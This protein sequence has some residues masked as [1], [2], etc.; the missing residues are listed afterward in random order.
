MGECQRNYAGFAAYFSHSEGWTPRNEALMEAV[1]K[2]AST[3]RHPWLVAGDSNMNPED[4]R[5]SLCYKS[6]HQCSLRRQGKINNMEV[7]AVAFPVDRDKEIQELR[8]ADARD[9]SLWRLLFGR[10]SEG[11]VGGNPSSCWVVSSF[12]LAQRFRGSSPVIPMRFLQ[13][14]VTKQLLDLTGREK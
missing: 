5:K 12:T 3:T 14:L 13:S 4:F 11:L 1:V 2:Q 10:Q 7:V 8:T 6:R 9:R